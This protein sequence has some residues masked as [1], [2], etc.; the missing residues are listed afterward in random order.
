MPAAQKKEEETDF[1]LFSVL[2]IALI[3]VLGAL[4]IFNASKAKPETF[5]QVYFDPE[6]LP[7]KVKAGEQLPVN[8]FIDNREG[9]RTEYSWKIKAENEIKAQGKI[10]V[11]VGQVKE[12]NEKISFQNSYAEK[13]KILVEVLKAGAKEAYT[14]WFF[15]K[16]E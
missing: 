6:K 15:V 3:I 11:E 7:E 2:V 16:V 13:Q 4:I 12:L 8:F 14:I 5:S 10:S 1:M 9:A